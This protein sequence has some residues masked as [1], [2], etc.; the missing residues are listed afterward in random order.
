MEAG[1]G[2]ED[3]GAQ[4]RLSYDT[5]HITWPCTVTNCSSGKLMAGLLGGNSMDM[6]TL[7]PS[8]AVNERACI[9]SSDASTAWNP[10]GTLDA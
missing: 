4:S 7:Q 9:R 5:S 3:H 6:L 10:D 2:G 8:K 1:D